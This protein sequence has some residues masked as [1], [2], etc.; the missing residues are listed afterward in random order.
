[1][2]GTNEC[3]LDYATDSDFPIYLYIYIYIFDSPW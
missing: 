3:L 1:M 2:V